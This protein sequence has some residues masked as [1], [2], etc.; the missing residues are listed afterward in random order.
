[1]STPRL[2]RDA[3]AL[4]EMLCASLHEAG[5]NEHHLDFRGKHPALVFSRG[6]RSH[7]VSFSLT[8]SDQRTALN[9]RSTLRKILAQTA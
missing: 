5:V 6:G 9:T 7:R 1:M 2:S 8:P 4:Y 3:R